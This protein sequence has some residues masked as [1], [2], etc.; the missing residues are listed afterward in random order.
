M[1][2]IKIGIFGL[3]RGYNNAKSI[4]LNDGE[5]VLD[6][7][8]SEVFMQ[9]ETIKAAGLEL[10]QCADICVRLRENGVNIDGDFST[11]SGAVDAISR[12]LQ[13]K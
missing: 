6:G 8:P 11:M 10:P 9:K 5:I 2:K 3:Y 13:N 7:K 12:A 4:M 1:K